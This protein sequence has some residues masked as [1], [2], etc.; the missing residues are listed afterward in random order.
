MEKEEKKV[1]CQNCKVELPESK[2]A[3]H[4]GFCL[5][6]NKYCP[7]CSKVFIAGEFEEHL[8]THNIP[9]EN[10]QK[11]ETNNKVQE[12][13]PKESS[14]RRN[15]ACAKHGYGE[16]Q[17]QPQKEEIKPKKV[18]PPKKK[19]IHI[20]DSLGVQKCEFCENVFE[21]LKEH[22]QECEVRLFIEKER[23]EYYKA[24]AELNEKDKKLAMKLAK[25]KEMN[26]D[27]DLDLAK[28]LQKELEKNKIMNIDHDLEIAEK[29]HKEQSKMIDTNDENFAKR[30]QDELDE[31]LAKELAQ[32]MSANDDNNDNNIPNEID[33]DV[34]KAIEASKNDK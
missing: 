26:V 9:Q 23:A 13:E 27:N 25:E 20:D 30:L 8:K 21:N 15:C 3:I 5:R 31:K 6:N 4:Q 33:E 1:I 7:T 2:L 22:L 14:H 28:E 11:K 18:E 34:L 24:I 32:K 17:K 19:P 12:D 29:L 16:N 10:T